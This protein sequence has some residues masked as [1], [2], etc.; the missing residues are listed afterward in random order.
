M[1]YNINVLKSVIAMFVNICWKRLFAGAPS[2]VSVIPPEVKNKHRE[3]SLFF[4]KECKSWVKN[5]FF[6]MSET[7]FFHDPDYAFCS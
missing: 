2:L 7:P 3:R 5:N 6:Y 1:N 4:A